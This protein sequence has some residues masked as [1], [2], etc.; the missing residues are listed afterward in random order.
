MLPPARRT[1]RL[2]IAA[3]ALEEVAD[4]IQF[5]LGL[6]PATQRATATTLAQECLAHSA[7]IDAAPLQSAGVYYTACDVLPIYMPSDLA[8]TK[9]IALGGVGAAATHRAQAIGAVPAFFLDHHQSDAA[10]T[11]AGRANRSDWYYGTAANPTPCTAGRGQGMQ[12]DEFPNYSMFEGGKDYTVAPPSLQ[13]MTS[14]DNGAEGTLLSSFY[15]NT[16]NGCNIPDLSGK[17][18]GD[19]V[20][21]SDPSSFFVLPLID[22]NLTNTWLC[23]S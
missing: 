21:D 8:V 23:R 5:K 19:I 9:P 18:V 10:K 20:D 11:A 15:A 16:T 4:R 2:V 1:P 17:S 6:D 13:L 22:V 3:T 14:Q 7:A 12:C